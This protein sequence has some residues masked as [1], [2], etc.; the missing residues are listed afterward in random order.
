MTDQF[1]FEDRYELI[2]AHIFDGESLFTS[3]TVHTGLSFARGQKREAS[4]PSL[5]RCRVNYTP[6]PPLFPG[7]HGRQPL[8]QVLRSVVRSLQSA[9]PDLGA[10]G[11]G[12]RTF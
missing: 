4:V 3:E 9:G 8:Y 10:A 2:D 6:F 7:S 11:P 1:L 12:P 5:V